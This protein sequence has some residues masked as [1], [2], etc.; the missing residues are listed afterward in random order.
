MNESAFPPPHPNPTYFHPSLKGKQA[1]HKGKIGQPNR[2]LNG[3]LI[4][5]IFFPQRAILDKIAGHFGQEKE[6]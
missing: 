4:F 3:A 6:V 1:A 5:C 2:A